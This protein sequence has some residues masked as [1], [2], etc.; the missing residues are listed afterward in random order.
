MPWNDQSGDP[1]R[2]GGGQGPWGGGPRRPW[3]Q[4]QPPR[5]K[6]P[7]GP[8]LEEMLRQWRERFFGGGGSGGG[9]GA[10]SGRRGLQWP[11]IAGV[12]I[13]G[14]LLAGVYP[15]NEGE[16]GVVTRL[17]AY[18]RTTTPG[19]H[20]HL[21]TPFEA[22]QVVNVTSQRSDEIGCDRTSSNCPD[23]EEG[24]MLTGDRN[25]V[26]IH[27]KVY[28][29][30]SDVVAFTFNVRN[31]INLER[32]SDL[33]AVGQVI[34]SA[35]REV[36]GRR[37]LEPIITT[38]RAVVEQEVQ[39]LAQQVLDEYHS[40]VRILQVQ[41]LSAKVPPEVAPA[42][43]DVI[44]ANQDAQTAVNNANRDAAV[45][46]N[47]AEAYK[48]RTIREASGE[49]ARFNSVYEEYRQAPQVTRDRIYIETMERVYRT[50]DLVILDQRAGAVPYLP[51]DGMIRRSGTTPARPNAGAN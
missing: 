29:N 41:L 40:G 46:L 9:S 32:T 35:M 1:P 14:W 39:Q 43:R 26:D 27:F 10:G 45:I 12:F 38:D 50:G 20:W 24:L 19:L 6:P 8:D 22:A 37:D 4:Q 25:I 2:G 11:V 48:G 28:Y 31:P 33:G 42:F 13:A 51:L 16:L 17:G 36:V 7:Q 30:I 5:S 49:A 23:A 44:T 47:E 3:G 21:P 18:N 15:V 34:E